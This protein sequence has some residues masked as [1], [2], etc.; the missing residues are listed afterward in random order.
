VVDKGRIVMDGPRDTV[1]ARLGGQ[2]P[3]AITG[4]PAAAPHTNKETAS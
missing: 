4:R 1:L 2:T 3:N